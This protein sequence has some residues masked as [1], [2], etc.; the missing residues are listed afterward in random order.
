ME[1]NRQWTGEGI[2]YR[3]RSFDRVRKEMKLAANSS[4]PSEGVPL[5]RDLSFVYGGGGSSTAH[6]SHYS[7][8]AV[9]PSGLSP[10][11]A[12][13]G[14]AGCGSGHP[15]PSIQGFLGIG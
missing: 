11:R 8:G 3:Q 6:R 15:G 1:Q 4:P 14:D 13:D 2:D 12:T 5:R 10:R 7:G 9:G